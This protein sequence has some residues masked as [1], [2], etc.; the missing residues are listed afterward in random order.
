MTDATP[1]GAALNYIKKHPSITDVLPA[2]VASWGIETPR[3]RFESPRQTLIDQLALEDERQVLLVLIDGMGHDLIANSFAYTPFLRSRRNDIIEASTVIPST[4]AAAIT[5]FATAQPAGMTRMVGWSVKDLRKVITLISFEGAAVSPEEWQPCDTIFQLARIKGVDSAAVSAGKFA[6]SGLT[7]AALRG[8]R[9]VGAETLDE[10]IDAA[11]AELKKGT[12]I[13]YLYWS[14]L[15]H[16]GHGESPDSNA[17]TEE[18]ERVDAGL[19]RI[20]RLLPR[21]VAAIVTADHGMISTSAKTRFDLANTPELAEGIDVIAGEGRM[22]H[23]HAKEDPSGVLERWEEFLGE[24]ATIVRKDDLANVLGGQPGAD[25]VGDGMA[26]MHGSWVV[27][28]SR[29]QPAGMIGL[30]GV[31]GSIS[32][33]EMAIPILRFD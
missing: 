23:I 26:L 11:I 6:N 8:T 10:R 2:A 14:E 28:D 1:L 12:P 20:S 27:V 22:V 5:A 4:T 13:V 31:H 32:K 15:D 30:K 21:G 18:L 29:T 19:A 3:P 33:A 16:T 17:W 7:R 9:H 25:L 24:R